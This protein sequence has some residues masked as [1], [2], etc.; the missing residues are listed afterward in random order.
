MNK[1]IGIGRLTKDIE[2]KNSAGGSSYCKFTIAVDR[3]NRK[4]GDQSADFINCTAF[5]KTA[6][7]IAQYFG[8][9]SKIVVEG[10]IETGSYKNKSGETVYTTDIMVEGVEFGESRSGGNGTAGQGQAQ[11][12]QAPAAAMTGPAAMPQ[13]GF[14]QAGMMPQQ[15]YQPGFQ[16]GMPYQPQPGYQQSFMQPVKQP[17]SIGAAGEAFM[18]IPDAVE[19]EGLPFA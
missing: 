6:E 13:T 4:D 15:G 14:Q 10:R 9:G 7:F 1:W 17:P 5:G 18:Q 19:D 8:R 2:L 12:Q 3:R 16:Q 11:R